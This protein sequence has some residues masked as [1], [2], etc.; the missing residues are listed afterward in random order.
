MCGALVPWG[1]CRRPGAMGCVET[2]AKGGVKGGV[3]ETW[4]HGMCGD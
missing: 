4:H 1:V 2:G 3:E